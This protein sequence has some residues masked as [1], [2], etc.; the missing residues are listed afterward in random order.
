MKITQYQTQLGKLL[1]NLHALEFAIRAFL[2]KINENTEPRVDINSV[3]EGDWIEI[4]SF[5]NYDSLKRLVTK[6][7][8][9]LGSTSAEA[10]D[11][12]VIT[13]RDALAHGR[14]ASRTPGLSTLELY[15]FGQPNEDKVQVEIKLELD[16]ELL[17]K[18]INLADAQIRKIIRASNQ[19]SLDIMDEPKQIT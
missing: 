18:Y 12:S 10:I 16:D 13:I 5:T 8:N 9:L 15:K 11:P 14:I 19:R 1:M 2:V 17:S 4:N 6:Y 7:N 3:K